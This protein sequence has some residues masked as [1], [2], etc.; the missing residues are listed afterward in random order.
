M[1]TNINPVFLDNEFIIDSDQSLIIDLGQQQSWDFLIENWKQRY[2]DIPEKLRKN[3]TSYR[4]ILIKYLYQ[5]YLIGHNPLPIDWTPKLPTVHLDCK[6]EYIIEQ[7]W[8][9]IVNS[10]INHNNNFKKLATVVNIHETNF[11]IWK[12]E[13]DY[14]YYI[15]NYYYDTYDGAG[16]TKYKDNPNYSYWDGSEISQHESDENDTIDGI[17]DINSDVI[18]DSS[19]DVI[20]DSSSGDESNTQINNKCICYIKLW[21]QFRDMVELAIDSDFNCYTPPDLKQTL[22]KI[23]TNQKNSEWYVNVGG[24]KVFQSYLIPYFNIISS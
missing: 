8:D 4:K 9:N 1:N 18:M 15:E 6:W 10:T 24:D 17:V 23:K 11:E 21:K 2:D 22:K 19:S 14:Y 3:E 20:M 7:N 5:V 13:I 16:I 12:N